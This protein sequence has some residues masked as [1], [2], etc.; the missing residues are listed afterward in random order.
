MP[1]V[2]ATRIRSVAR[3]S[4]LWLL[5]TGGSVGVVAGMALDVLRIG[6]HQARALL[7]ARRAEHCPN[8]CA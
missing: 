7:Q 1:T 2:P 3:G 6:L 4:D 8:G 5:L